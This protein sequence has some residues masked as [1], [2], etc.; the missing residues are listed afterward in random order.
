MIPTR[1]SNHAPSAIRADVLS[2]LDQKGHSVLGSFQIL[3]SGYHQ[4]E[5]N[6]EGKCLFSFRFLNKLKFY[7]DTTSPYAVVDFTAFNHLTSI[8]STQ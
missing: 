6:D 3:T 7:L 2:Q 5:N 1:D 4:N 8:N